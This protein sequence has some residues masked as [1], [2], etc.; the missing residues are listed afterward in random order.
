VLS[1]VDAFTRECLAPEVDTGFATQR[2]TRVLDEIIAMRGLPRA[3]RCNNGPELTSRP[4]LA[5]AL[6]RKIELQHIQPVKPTRNAHVESFH[7]RRR[8]ERLQVSW[9]TNIFDAP[10][11]VTDWKVKYNEQRPH[12]NLGYRASAEF[13][14]V[15][16]TQSYGKDAGSAHLEN[17][18]GVSHFAIAPATG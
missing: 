9:F 17:A 14:R 7:G 3:V 16:L 15:V 5:S 6:D 18:S 8:G 12:S 4:F 13:A 11:K 1:V 2:V 10:R